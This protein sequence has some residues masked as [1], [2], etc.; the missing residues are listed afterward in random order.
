MNE[1]GIPKIIRADSQDRLV[2]E[3]GRLSQV[4]ESRLHIKQASGSPLFHPEELRNYAPPPGHFLAHMITMGAYERYGENRNHDAWPH[5]ELLRKHATFETHA[6]NYR[7]HRNTSDALALGV[8][9]A[10]RYCPVLQRGE[11]LMWSDIKK[12]EPEFV[13]AAAGEELAG[14]MAARVKHD[15]CGVCGFISENPRSRCNCIRSNA[16]RYY[17]EK[18]AYAIMFNVDPTFKDYSYVGRP[19][20]RIAH[21][22]NYMFHAKAAS[23]DRELRGD[24]LAIA[25]GF[26][27]NEHL[28][29]V[30]ELSNSDRLML[31][32]ESPAKTAATHV[33]PYVYT[34]G[35]DNSVLRK[36]AS[37]DPGIVMRVMADRGVVLPL[38]DFYSW[39]RGVDRRTA[40]IDTTV[41]EAAAKMPGIRIMILQRAEEYPQ[42][43]EIFEDQCCE[44]APA[45][46]CRNPGSGDPIATFFDTAKDRFA[47]RYNILLKDAVSNAQSDSQRSLIVDTSAPSEEAFTLGLLYNAYLAKTASVG[48]IEDPFDIMALASLR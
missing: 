42:I 43:A 16:G 32:D 25:Y 27:G 15:I 23:T 9:K 20:D 18:R 31:A 12:A 17:P 36:M 10:A 35:V 29:F 48:R 28:E 38:V 34:D 5:A 2:A 44:F 30:R 33:L 14:S 41:K 3:V 7:E 11:V 26:G 37:Q 1:K 13:K 46:S 6:K 24:E 22:L 4:F 45:D 8:I 47:A 19:A 40:E 21:Y 39:I